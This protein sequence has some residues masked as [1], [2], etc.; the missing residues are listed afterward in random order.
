MATV[1][2][3][4][5]GRSAA[6]GGT[7]TWWG[8]SIIGRYALA[9]GRAWVAV[10]GEAYH[11]P[12]RVII[13]PPGA[14]AFRTRGASVNLD[15]APQPG[16]LWRT[17]LRTLSGAEAVFV[18]RDAASGLSRRNVVVVSSLSWRF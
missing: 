14:A 13:V 8:S 1:D 5:Q 15:V 16:V 10:R 12:D 3:G 17:E 4:R 6:D 9:P 18:D 7:A 2:L 11:D